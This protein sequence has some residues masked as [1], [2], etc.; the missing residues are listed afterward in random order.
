ML[1]QTDEAA[2]PHPGSPPWKGIS[3]NS[4]THES[5]APQLRSSPFK[6]EVRRGMG[7]VD[8]KPIPTPTLPLKGREA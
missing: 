7:H 1:H 4:T 2:D 5:G 6:G 3:V 8:I